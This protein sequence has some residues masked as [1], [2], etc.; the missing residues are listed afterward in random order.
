MTSAGYPSRPNL[1]VTTMRM[2]TSYKNG[3]SPNYGPLQ[4]TISLMSNNKNSNGHSY[5]S[6]S[7]NN[8]NSNPTRT[9][10]QDK[11]LPPSQNE[12]QTMYNVPSRTYLPPRNS[13]PVTQRPTTTST[14]TPTTTTSTTEKTTTTTS[15]PQNSDSYSVPSNSN[16]PVGYPR[17]NPQQQQYNINSNSNANIQNNNGQQNYNNNNYNY[18]QTQN[19]YIPPSQNTQSEYSSYQQQEQP[20]LNSFGYPPQRSNYLTNN[21]NYPYSNSVSDSFS[22]GTQSLPTNSYSAPQ[23]AATLSQQAITSQQ[24]FEE[25]AK[26]PIVVNDQEEELEGLNGNIVDAELLQRVQ[27]IIEAHERQQQAWLDQV[28]KEKQDVSEA[29]SR[30]QV[31][32]YHP[33]ANANAGATTTSNNGYEQ[34]SDS[35]SA[36]TLYRETTRNSNNFIGDNYSGSTPPQGYLYNREQQSLFGSTNGGSSYP[37]KSASASSPRQRDGTQQSFVHT[38]SDNKLSSSQGKPQ[39][40]FFCL[41]SLLLLLLPILIRWELMDYMA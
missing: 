34:K 23:P 5:S 41:Y 8:G 12:P 26:S 20:Q 18:P 3:G 19:A 4:Y 29:A 16:S 27:E 7:T 37:Q 36:S 2:D 13:A 35:S 1:E 17:N 21:D 10:G 31:D 14:T 33:K 6:T 15:L 9:S 30:N 25:S 24:Q 11:Y 38:S 40:I 32:S 28:R 39:V 22:T